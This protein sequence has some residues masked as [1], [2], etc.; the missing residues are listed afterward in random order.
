MSCS[1]C[2]KWSMHID[3]G[4]TLLDNTHQSR[5]MITYFWVPHC[6]VLVRESG[7]LG[8][9]QNVRC[10]CGEWLIK[11]A[12]LQ[13]A[14]LDVDWITRKNARCATRKMRPLITY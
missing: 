6:S 14:W 1:C 9:L 2:L 4:W 11:G 7:S 3:G 5:I 13:I 10:S 8:H 12:G